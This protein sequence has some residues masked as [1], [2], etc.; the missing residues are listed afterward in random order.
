MKTKV[1]TR[2]TATEMKFM[3]RTAKYTWLDHKSKEDIKRTTVKTQI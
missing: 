3:R 2:I 1:K